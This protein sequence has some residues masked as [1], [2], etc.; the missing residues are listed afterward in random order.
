[1]NKHT[2]KWLAAAAVLLV[3]ILIVIDSADR[4]ESTVESAALIP[5]LKS[6]LNDVRKITITRSGDDVALIIVRD[7][8]NWLVSDRDDYH[9]DVSKIRSVLLSVADARILERKTSNPERYDALGIQAPDASGSSGVALTIAGDSFEHTLIIGNT[10]QSDYRY[11]RIADRAQGLLIDR[12]P[13]IPEAGGEWLQPE[14]IDVD[15][16]KVRAVTIEHADGAVI[17]VRQDNEEGSTYSVADIPEGRELSYPS[18]A[19]GIAGV[20]GSL[21]LDDVRKSEA[22]EQA[23]TTAFETFDD[24]KIT[25]RSQKFGED[26]WIELAVEPGESAQAAAIN[27]RVAGWQYKIASYKANLLMRRWEDILKAPADIE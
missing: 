22:L 26:T 15:A 10:A 3:G 21:T 17:H 27:E 23:V 20:L 18:V 7:A 2:L 25:V 11:V 4:N 19:N 14:I 9:A 8:E 24:M 5:E 12:D 16:A 6:Q 13:D 1:M